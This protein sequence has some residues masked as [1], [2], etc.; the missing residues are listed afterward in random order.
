MNNAVQRKSHII[1][2]ILFFYMG[3][4]SIFPLAGRTQQGDTISVADHQAIVDTVLAYAKAFDNGDIELLKKMIHPE[5]VKRGL[6]IKGR[7]T[8]PLSML[9]YSQMLHL[10]NQNRMRK[11]QKV[12]KAKDLHSQVILHRIDGMIANVTLIDDLYIEY[13]S[14]IRKKSGWKIL[15]VLWRSR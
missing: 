7:S 10:S 3:L 5:I 15:Q 4:F 11:E 13:L 9:N 14:L 1:V 2:T 12:L 6:Y 8:F